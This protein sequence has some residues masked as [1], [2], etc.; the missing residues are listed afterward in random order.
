MTLR[1]W[2]RLAAAALW[3]GLCLPMWA[4]TRLFGGGEAWVRRFLRG[5]GWIL[6][7]RVRI[8][9]QAIPGP[10]LYV[11]N[12]ITFLDIL[13]LGGVAPARFVAKAEIA[14][15]ALVGFLAKVGGTIFVSRERR[16]ETRVQADR[17]AAA[18][19]GRRPV[20]L[21]GEGATG[22]GTALLPFRAPLFVSAIE[23]R[24]PV[25]PVAIDYGP[26]RA[27]HAWPDD[28]GFGTEAKRLL[29]RRAP[30][31]VTLRFLARLDPHTP[32][33]KALAAAA[34]AAI[35]DA[36]DRADRAVTARP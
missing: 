28:V 8:E 25:Q 19:A 21:F 7:L 23:A 18:L 6:G 1:G 4:L 20:V 14:D 24:A 32:D 35:A 9:G 30:V 12:H 36:L 15:W 13:A 26:A 27:D 3:L 22:D 10:A 5:I 29:N 16:G 11:A 31:P 17:V 33:R 34:Q 2:V